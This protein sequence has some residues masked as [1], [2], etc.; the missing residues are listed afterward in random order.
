VLRN[1]QAYRLRLALCAAAA[2]LCFCRPAAA[3]TIVAPRWD[4]WV[5]DETGKPVAGINITEVHEDFSCESVDHSE[6]M[7]TDEHGHAQFHARYSKWHP[8]MCTYHTTGEF[9]SFGHHS[10]GR[11]AT[12]TAGDPQGILFGKNVDKDGHVI[13]WLGSPD[14]L[15]SHII[16]HRQQPK[17]IKTASP[18]AAPPAAPSHQ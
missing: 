14:H 3:E 5:V 10:R 11:H 7:F 8:I 9:L 13:E 4:V 12:V 6:T 1:H 15:T 18:P 2:L 16:V 17:N